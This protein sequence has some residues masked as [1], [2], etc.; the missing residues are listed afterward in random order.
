MND[1]ASPAWD[2]FEED[3]SD[4]SMFDIIFTIIVVLAAGF[5][6]YTTYLGFSYD[7]PIIPSIVIATIIGLGLLII[8]FKIREHR[9]S[10][11]GV[12]KPLIAFFIF[13]IFSFISNTNA[14]YTYFLQN[15]IVSKTQLN[16]WQSFDEGTEIIVAALDSN[17]DMVDR[18][19]VGHLLEVARKNLHDQITDTANPGLGEKARVHL[20][21]AENILG[22]T[23]TRLRAPS[24]A[25]S[26]IVHIKYADRL[27]AL[28]VSI[29]N[30]KYETGK[31]SE[32]ESLKVE[33]NNLKKF[34]SD[35]ITLGEYSSET[36]DLMQKDMSTILIKAEN[37][38]GFSEGIPKINVTADDIGSFQYTWTNF[39]DGIAITAIILSVLLSLMLD[40]LAPI[41]SLLLYKHE[42]EY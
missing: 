41:L 21:E 8:N 16:A 28:I 2:E 33:I 15:D 13:L 19:N 4:P 12:G 5:S 39:A 9:I 34:Y 17:D 23:T 11:D 1:Y 18:S 40:I 35:K 30:K 27:D 3:K 6:G 31:V 10:G 29:Y 25:D 24:N 26:Q 38:I 37:L 42:V 36:T 22:V 14:I 20:A 7:L 32:I